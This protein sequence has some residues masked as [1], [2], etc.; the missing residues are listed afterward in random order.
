[1]SQCDKSG[2]DPGGLGAFIQDFIFGRI[3]FA[4]PAHPSYQKSLVWKQMY[5]MVTRV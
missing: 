3:G 5:I 4:P 1:M 2:K